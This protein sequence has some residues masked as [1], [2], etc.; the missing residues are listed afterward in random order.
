MRLFPGAWG[1]HHQAAE[2]ALLRGQAVKHVV[3]FQYENFA[4]CL[5][6]H[7]FL[8]VVSLR[9]PHQTINVCYL[10]LALKSE[11]ARQPYASTAGCQIGKQPSRL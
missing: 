1:W 2:P 10:G 6:S 3:A 11:I 7:E 5:M 9:P 8:E 4:P